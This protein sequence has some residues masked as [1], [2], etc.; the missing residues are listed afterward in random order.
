MKVLLIPWAL[1]AVVGCVRSQPPNPLEVARRQLA[2]GDPVAAAET[3]KA[4][5]ARAP[6][7]AAAGAMLTDMCTR[8]E[9]VNH[10]AG[11]ARLPVDLVE[12]V[13][14]LPHDPSCWTEGLELDGETFPNAG[15]LDQRYIQI[16]ISWT[17]K[18]VSA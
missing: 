2:E 14:S 13:G 7:A 10:N 9:L 17:I 6:E 3:L 18:D 4:I 11:D 15:V 8:I 5:L 12:V 1:M 16:L